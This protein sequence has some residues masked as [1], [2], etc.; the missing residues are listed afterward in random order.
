MSMKDYK[1]VHVK[2]DPMSEMSPEE[3]K[4]FQDAIDRG[5]IEYTPYDDRKAIKQIEQLFNAYINI[6]DE[7]LNNALERA[8]KK[9]NDDAFDEVWENTLKLAASDPKAKEILYKA[10]QSNEDLKKDFDARANE[11]AWTPEME[12]DWGTNDTEYEFGWAN[13]PS[14]DAIKKLEQQL[15]E[16]G[17][18]EVTIDEVTDDGDSV[19]HAVSESKRVKE[20]HPDDDESE[21]TWSIISN[22]LK[23]R[24]F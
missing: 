12:E 8:G 16:D 19:A 11:E 18:G 4:I 15:D 21:V 13:G 3:Q 20:E 22:A 14:D 1:G 23:D 9:F 6:P 7:A 2:V 10:I 5:A 24:H 17:D